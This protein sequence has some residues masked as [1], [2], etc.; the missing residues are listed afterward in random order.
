MA[1][2]QK[3]ISLNHP[4]VIIT[5]GMPSGAF[6]CF[7]LPVTVGWLSKGV[8]PIKTVSV[9]GAFITVLATVMDVRTY[10]QFRDECKKGKEN[11]GRSWVSPVLWLFYSICLL[12][13][14]TLWL[15][16]DKEP[17]K[18]WYPEIPSIVLSW[19]KLKDKEQRLETIK[20]A[21]TKL[22]LNLE[23]VFKEL[24]GEKA[25]FLA[26][27]QRVAEVLNKLIQRAVVNNSA[28]STRV[29]KGQ[30]KHI[31]S[32]E[33]E[34][35]RLKT[36]GAKLLEEKRDLN[37]KLEQEKETLLVKL[38][39]KQ[40]VIEGLNKHIQSLKEECKTLKTSETKLLA[41]KQDL[42]KEN[43]ELKQEKARV[44]AEIQEL[45]E[46]RDLLF[47]RDPTLLAGFLTRLKRE[48]LKLEEERD[49][50]ELKVHRLEVHRLE[51]GL[52][53]W[54]KWF[55]VYS[56]IFFWV[57]IIGIIICVIIYFIYVEPNPKRDHEDAFNDYD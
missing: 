32:L 45:T 6:I 33:E 57:G 8:V 11:P 50:L 55:L 53:A 15:V 37:K 43:E 38:A 44:L 28:H 19:E 46:A 35:K 13:F 31:Q 42:E 25:E 27:K 9:F 2:R 3:S 17:F 48:K 16:I 40:R 5:S 47:Y 1:K 14:A 4:R 7:F 10:R 22:T 56:G 41:E 30:N 49:K 18:G 26:E 52:I 51:K 54:G 24:K 36:S 34:C 20:E 21:L 23:E 39:E 12:W 29:I